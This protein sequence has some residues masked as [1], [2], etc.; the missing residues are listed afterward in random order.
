MVKN[1]KDGS[2]TYIIP[3]KGLPTSQVAEEN[4]SE[5]ISKYSKTIKYGDENGDS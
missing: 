5:I 3:V 4:I 2:V 1:N